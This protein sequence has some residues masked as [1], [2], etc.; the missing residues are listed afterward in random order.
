MISSKNIGVINEE[1]LSWGKNDLIE[2]NP[3]PEGFSWVGSY[4]YQLLGS[5]NRH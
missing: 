1:L 2:Y 4:T 5:T 3:N